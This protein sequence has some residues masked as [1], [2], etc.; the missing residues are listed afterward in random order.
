M[1]VLIT[2]GN[3]ASSYKILKAFEG[4]QILL[5]DYGEI[6]VFNAGNYQFISLGEKNDDTIAHHLLNVCLDHGVDLFL[7]LH[8]FEITA[9]SKAIILFEEFN[10][11]VLLPE[12]AALPLYFHSQEDVRKGHNWG[13]FVK[14]VL[15]FSPAPN[16]ALVEIGIEKGL[17]GVFFVSPKPEELTVILFTIP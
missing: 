11:Q 9:V 15:T 17:N 5:A 6:P 3:S 4:S 1:K 2:G 7:P 8:E 10:I 13:V 16:D 14:G 12:Q